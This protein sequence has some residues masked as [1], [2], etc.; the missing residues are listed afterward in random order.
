M[1]KNTEKNIDGMPQKLKKQRNVKILGIK[2]KKEKPS[3]LWCKMRMHLLS[4]I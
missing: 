1:K 2:H 4:F 3:I